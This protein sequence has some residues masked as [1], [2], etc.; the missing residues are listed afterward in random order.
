MRRKL[1][2]LIIILAIILAID[3]L[4]CIS[5]ERVMAKYIAALDNTRTAE[6]AKVTR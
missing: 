4:V 3:A 1:R 2:I 6:E 5:T